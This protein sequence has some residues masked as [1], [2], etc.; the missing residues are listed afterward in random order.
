MRRSSAA[1][2]ALVA[3]ASV[4]LWLLADAKPLTARFGPA[5]CRRIALIDAHNGWR[6]GGGEDLALTSDGATLIVSAHDRLDAARP[7]GGLYAVPV[8]ELISAETVI[9]APLVDPGARSTPFRP[10]GIGLSPDG[11]RLAL[12]NRVAHDEAVVEIGRLNGSSW[13][14]ETVVRDPRL[15]RAND[16]VFDSDGD[17]L[18]VSVD[19]ADC[20]TSLRDLVPGAHTGSLVRV[21]RGRLRS[22]RDGLSFP[23]GI[24]AGTIA[25]TRGRRLLRPDG[26]TV[27]LPGAPD[28]LSVD[29]D[30][31][32]AAVHPDLLSLWFYIRGWADHAAS[33]VLRVGAD[34]VV[35]MLF[36]DPSGAQFSAATV[37]VMAGGR[38]IAGSARDAGILVCGQTG[39]AT[40]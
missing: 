15:C 9:A 2:L 35:E 1:A 16:L 10:H 26:R 5:D 22:V 6:I 38:L 32:I 25:E 11:E 40:A 23:N 37:G 8:H 20:G 13:R 27:S 12:V 36:D 28:N 17:A 7:D 21:E 34:D 33:R 30:A 29:G 31:L 18:L 4:L 19:R 39:R 14:S 3:T 24:A